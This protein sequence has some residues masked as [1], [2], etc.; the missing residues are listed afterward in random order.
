MIKKEQVRLVQVRDAEILRVI[1][2]DRGWKLRPLEAE[3]QRQLRKKRTPTIGASRSTLS[4]LMTGDA[5][6]VRSTVAKALAEVLGVKWQ[7]LFTDELYTVNREVERSA[8]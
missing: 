7:S 6:V 5:K 4:N 8:A 3:V 1:V 2:E